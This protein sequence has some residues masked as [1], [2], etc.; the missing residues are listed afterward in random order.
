MGKFLDKKQQVYDFKLTSYGRHMLSQGTLVPS[1]YAFFDDNIIYDG[2]Y[3]GMTGSQNS[4]IDR[5]K[6]KTQ[7]MEG[8]VLFEDVES[9]T[10]ATYDD[11]GYTYEP[12]TGEYHRREIEFFGTKTP[13]KNIPRKDIF[14]FE[15]MLGD[16]YL[17]G[18]T[19]NI[20]AWKVVTLQG[21]ISSSQNNIPSGTLG[22]KFDIQIPQIDIQLTYNLKVKSTNE[23]AFSGPNL[24][25]I[26]KDFGNLIFFDDEKYLTLENDDLLVYT[27]ELN[28][29]LLNKNFEVEVFE[30]TGSQEGLEDI[31]LRKDFVRDFRSLNG[32][33]ITETYLNNLDNPY[34]EPNTNNVEYYFNINTDHM[35]D[36]QAACKGAEIF[37][38]DSYYID[39]DFECE[40]SD[41]D[42]TYYDIYGPVTEPEI[43]L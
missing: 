1:Y 9:I 4:I 40:E 37:N 41:I 39:I 12:E 30:V 31:L 38:K 2:A 8:Q 26:E 14:R 7:Y 18:N 24:F 13:T 21:Q 42:I 20:P 29:I 10:M 25:D 32:G 17:E 33:I 23:L 3:I 16:A 19:Q 6:N 27:E 28:T 35:I 11:E 5:I 15:Q 36:K 34:V 43:C 22:T